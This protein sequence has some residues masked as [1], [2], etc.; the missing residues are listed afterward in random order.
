MLANAW[1]PHTYFKL[2][3]GSRDKI[4]QKLDSLVL[5][6]SE[7]ILKFT[8]T[9]KKLLRKAIASQNLKDVISHL[10]KYGNRSGGAVLNR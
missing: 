4:A 2:S 7:P 3:F 6:I 1:Y 8:D 10:K 5:D 9:D